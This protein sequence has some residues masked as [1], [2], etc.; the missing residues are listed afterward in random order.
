MYTSSMAQNITL[1][2]TTG[3]GR[4]EDVIDVCDFLA[5]GDYG[6]SAN[7]LAVMARQSPLFKKIAKQN[8]NG[9]TDDPEAS[10]NGKG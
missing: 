8:G 3:G 2:R 1:D 10:G 7:A 5:E 6:S 9:K 4:Y